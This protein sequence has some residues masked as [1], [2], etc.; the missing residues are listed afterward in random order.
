VPNV[1]SLDACFKK[2]HLVNVGECLYSI[3]IDVSF[4]V[5]FERRKVDKK[6]NL[7]EK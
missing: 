1:I 7:H 2:F 4:H 3:K 6:E 5:Q